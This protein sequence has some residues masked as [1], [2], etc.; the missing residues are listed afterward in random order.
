MRINPQS[1]SED[2]LNNILSTYVLEIQGSDNDETPLE[3]RI[4][5]AKKLVFNGD[6]IILFSELENNIFLISK[7]E[8][9]RRFGSIPNC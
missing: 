9:I 3:N 7:D 1:V 6:I 8:C 5:A 2:A 4:L